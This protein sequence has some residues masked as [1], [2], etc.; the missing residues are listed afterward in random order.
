MLC[1]TGRIDENFSPRP[2]PHPL[3]KQSAHSKAQLTFVL[4]GC[5]H[6]A[7]SR[8]LPFLQVTKSERQVMKPLYDRYRLVKQILC[9]ASA[10]PVIVSVS[11]S[12]SSFFLPPPPTLC[13]HSAAGRKPNPQLTPAM[14]CRGN[15]WRLRRQP[16]HRRFIHLP[17]ALSP[18]LA[19]Q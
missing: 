15:R 4:L 3:R 16:C 10:I 9:R 12:F 2:M 14:P 11:F 5:K 7:H 1:A 6:R 13:D 18:A 8:A 19:A 17:E